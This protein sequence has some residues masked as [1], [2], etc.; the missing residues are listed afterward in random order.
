MRHVHQYVKGLGEKTLKVLAKYENSLTFD[1]R[2]P[3]TVVKNRQLAK[4]FSWPHG[5]ELHT[6]FC[7]FNLTI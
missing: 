1:G 6:F 3:G 7:N 2:C 5:T 4:H